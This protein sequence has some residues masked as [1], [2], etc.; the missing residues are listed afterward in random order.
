MTDDGAIP[1]KRARIVFIWE[2]LLPE[3]APPLEAELL[4]QFE[5]VRESIRFW[6]VRIL[7][8][9]AG[10]ILYSK[11]D[12]HKSDAVI[13]DAVHRWRQT[14]ASFR[15]TYREVGRE[16]GLHRDTVRKRHRKARARGTAEPQ[17]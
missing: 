2:T 6:L 13:M 3:G 7:R 8:A 15:R 14:G 11:V 5:S 4:K 16:L 10:D 12:K 1:R 17:G 9:Q